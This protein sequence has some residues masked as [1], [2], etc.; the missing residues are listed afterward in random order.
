MSFPKINILAISGSLRANSSNNA[1]INT[2]AELVYDEVNFV[3]YEGLGCLP[4][5]DDSKDPEPEVIAFRNL[6]KAADGVLIC[7][8]EYALA[9]QA[10]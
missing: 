5:F 8:P 6:L 4:H 2:A 7:S 3:I 1:V 9:Y 10:H